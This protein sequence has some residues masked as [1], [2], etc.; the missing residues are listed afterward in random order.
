MNLSPSP[1]IEQTRYYMTAFIATLRDTRHGAENVRA[2][3][4]EFAD[5]IIADDIQHDK[6]L[7]KGLE[8]GL[9]LGSCG[10]WAM[11]EREIEQARR[12]IKEARSRL[13][14]REEGTR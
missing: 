6:A 3:L 1:S 8:R 11:L 4:R 7:L 9:Y 12:E 2:V 13:S 14:A 10:Q 5:M